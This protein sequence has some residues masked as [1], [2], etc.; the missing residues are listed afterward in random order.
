M[1]PI[2]PQPRTTVLMG[3]APM[4]SVHAEFDD[5]VVAALEGP[6]SELHARLQRVREH[7][8][9]HFGQEDAWMR[10]NGFPAANCHIDE[11]AAVL[12]SAD[13]VL[14]LVEQGRHDIG[15]SF[16]AE[17][18]KWFPGHADYL[19]S[20]LAAWL[21]KRQYGGRPVAIHRRA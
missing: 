16:L 2:A 11:H 19:D 10:D 3:Y 14:P 5:V 17:L 8:V 9:S 6:D 4:D 21:C 20:A 13:E 1:D 7:L 15:R 12:K 18:Q